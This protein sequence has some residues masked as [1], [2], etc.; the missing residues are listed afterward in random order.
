MKHH[1]LM[2]FDLHFSAQVNLTPSVLSVDE[3]YSAEFSCTGT[4]PKLLQIN[5]NLIDPTGGRVTASA[6]D[7][8]GDDGDT[9]NYIFANTTRDDNG[10]TIQCFANAVGSN[11]ITLSVLN[12]KFRL[13]L[14][15]WYILLVFHDKY[16][17][18]RYSFKASCNDINHEIT[19]PIPAPN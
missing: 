19:Y 14:N 16:L 5:S 2:T 10:T 15:L 11:I 17:Y 7:S 4:G 18:T 12:N 9:I 8:S 13:S 6:D 3:G 1:F